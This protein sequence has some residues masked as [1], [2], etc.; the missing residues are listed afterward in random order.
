MSNLGLVLLYRE[1]TKKKHP[2]S[3]SFLQG[4]QTAVFGFGFVSFTFSERK[5]K[6]SVEIVLATA[7][8]DVAM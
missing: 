7:P 3:F 1:Y 4:F 6:S 8:H 2:K 5:K